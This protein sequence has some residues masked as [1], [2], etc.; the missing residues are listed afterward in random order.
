MTAAEDIA[1]LGDRAG[2]TVGDGLATYEPTLGGWTARV[3]SVRMAG[4]SYERWHVAILDPAGRARST[5]F[6]SLLGE[7]ARVAEARV[8]ALSGA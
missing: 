8:R 3:R 5:S 6:A 1:I 2:W 4:H 7:A